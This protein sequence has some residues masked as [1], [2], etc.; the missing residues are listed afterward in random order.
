MT[1]SVSC[2]LG[3]SCG[4]Q[5][6]AQQDTRW[7]TGEDEGQ[8]DTHQVRDRGEQPSTSNLTIPTVDCCPTKNSSGGVNDGDVRGGE[9]VSPSLSNLATNTIIDWQKDGQEELTEILRMLEIY[10]MP[11]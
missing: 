8:V 9:K 1:L 5:N 4:D 11:L 7:V 3:N 10:V 6:E 2:E